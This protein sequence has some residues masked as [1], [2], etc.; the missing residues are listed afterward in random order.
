MTEKQPG[1]APRVR[2]IEVSVKRELTVLST[3]PRDLIIAVLP[4]RVSFYADQLLRIF[5]IFSIFSQKLMLLL[6][7]S[8]VKK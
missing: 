5:L 3:R 4:R 2:L 1:P 8:E 6:I 7:I